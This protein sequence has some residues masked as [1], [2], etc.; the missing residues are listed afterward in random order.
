MKILLDQGLPRSTASLLRQSGIDAVHTSEI[1]MS[2][3][4]DQII[5][6]RGRAE[7]RIVVTLDAEFSSTSRLGSC[8]SPFSHSATN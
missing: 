1:G 3:A 2:R 8:E 6:D 5:L 7:D 4:D